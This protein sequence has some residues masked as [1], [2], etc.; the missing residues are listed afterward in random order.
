MELDAIL[1]MKGPSEC[2]FGEDSA[3]TVA[4]VLIQFVFPSADYAP[5]KACKAHL[6]PTL[7]AELLCTS[8]QCRQVWNDHGMS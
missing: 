1:H 2:K 5:L 6:F 4:A 8:T 3:A 7:I